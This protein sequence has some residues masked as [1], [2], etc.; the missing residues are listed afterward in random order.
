MKEK[1]V[2]LL[3]LIQIITIWVPWSF[4]EFFF[5]VGSPGVFLSYHLDVP[6]RYESV[7]V[8]IVVA[9]RNCSSLSKVWVC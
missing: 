2:L 6:I 7:R 8:L 9:T 5:D 3:K 4:L 1:F